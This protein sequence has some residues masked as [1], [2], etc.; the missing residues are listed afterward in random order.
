[1]LPLLREGRKWVV[2]DEI[3]L[4]DCGVARALAQL[5]D[6]ELRPQTYEYGRLFECFI[7]NQLRASLEYAGKQY[8][9]S[10]LRTKDG[11]EID[12]IVERAREPT[13]FIEIKSGS[14]VQDSELNNLRA[15]SRDLEGSEALCLYNG[16]KRL[17]SDGI[18]VLPWRE[19]FKE[20]GL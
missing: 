14:N 8:Q 7:V 2:V 11:A 16:A 12:L 15:L 13:W 9:L 18:P 19:G 1:M 6:V 4:F 3:Q 5:A 20:L 10:Y 17:L